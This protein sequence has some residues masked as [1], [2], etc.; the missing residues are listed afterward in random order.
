MVAKSS[1]WQVQL[2]ARY[3]EH[4]DH[5]FLAILSIWLYVM[6]FT[7]HC[8][9]PPDGTDSPGGAPLLSLMKQKNK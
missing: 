2:G 3:W 5:D 9:W 4:K 8:S 1:L 7:I 6:L